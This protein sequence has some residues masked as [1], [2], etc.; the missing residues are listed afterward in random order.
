M[1]QEAIQITETP[2]LPGPKLVQD[3]NKALLALGTDF[4][5]ADDP[6][7]F[8][9]PF[10]TWADTGSTPKMLRRRNEAGTAWVAEALLF[11]ESAKKG[12][13]ASQGFKAAPSAAPD[14]VVVRS[15]VIRGVLLAEGTANNSASVVLAWDD[16]NF[17]HYVV[18]W[19]RVVPAAPGVIYMQLS[20]DG[21]AT[22][23]NSPPGQSGLAWAR[24]D[25]SGGSFGAN[26]VDPGFRV[27]G[28]GGSNISSIDVRGSSGRLASSDSQ[29]TGAVSDQVFS[30][31]PGGHSRTTHGHFS[32]GTNGPANTVKFIAN[33]G[34]IKTGKFRIYGVR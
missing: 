9:K 4:A 17:D 16:T 2:P 20:A 5:G 11:E 15:E 10:M 30:A 33:S 32:A 18:E 27:C 34:L 13:D 19:R 3:I 29:F 1:T 12:G 26:A 31:D 7:A 6:A 25:V 14:D 21:G 23:Y 8:A 24:F 22:Y 28:G